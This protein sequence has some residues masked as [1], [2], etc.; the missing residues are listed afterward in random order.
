LNDFR[1][2]PDKVTPYYESKLPRNLQ[3]PKV[4]PSLYLKLEEK[5]GGES[6]ER[7]PPVETLHEEPKHELDIPVMY[8]ATSIQEI[9]KDLDS[10]QA[11]LTFDASNPPTY[12]FENKGITNEQNLMYV[13]STKSPNNR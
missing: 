10:I 2:H 6:H 7:A 4:V 11:V 1:Q 9:I 12:P 5:K 8:Q 3:D 13:S